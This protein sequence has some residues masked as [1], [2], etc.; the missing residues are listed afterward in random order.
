MVEVFEPKKAHEKL[1]KY[2]TSRTQSVKHY[3]SKIG[4]SY[5]SLRKFL[6]NPA[7]A[8]TDTIFKIGI[9]L[10]RADKKNNKK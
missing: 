8:R 6:T 9:F 7:A 1:I 5:T 2:M 4:I 3:A 10:A